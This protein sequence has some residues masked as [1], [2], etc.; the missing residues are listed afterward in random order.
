MPGCETLIKHSERKLQAKVALK[1]GPVKARF[2][3]EVEPNTEGAP[4]SYSLHGKS[5]AGAAGHA[6]G[7]AD[8][9]LEDAG[10]P[11]IL[12]CTAKVQIGGKI[13]QLGSRLIMG[14]AKNLRLVSFPNLLKL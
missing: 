5:N 9:T 14:T 11:T 13:A 3:G 1:I 8:V 6:K 7:G 2:L 12:R 10:L 4:D